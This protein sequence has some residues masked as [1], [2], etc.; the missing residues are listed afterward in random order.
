MTASWAFLSI[1][2]L[3]MGTGVR[4]KGQIVAAFSTRLITSPFLPIRQKLENRSTGEYSPGNVSLHV[5][6]QD[7]RCGACEPHTEMGDRPDFGRQRGERDYRPEW[8]D[9]IHK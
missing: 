8:L 7:L 4:D 2:R 5:L 1:G 6:V 9:S 3:E